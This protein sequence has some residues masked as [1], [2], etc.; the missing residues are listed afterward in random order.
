MARKRKLADE[1]K[2]QAVQDL[3][4]GKDTIADICARYGISQT[5]LYKLRDRALEAMQTALKNPA[6]QHLTK[7]KHLEHELSQ[8]KQLIADQA[9]IISVLKKRR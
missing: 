6:N 8:A 4:Q 3:L 7:E 5:Y 9:I 2:L 1:D